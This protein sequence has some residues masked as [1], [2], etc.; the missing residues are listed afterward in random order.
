MREGQIEMEQFRQATETLAR[1]EDFLDQ[2]RAFM[3]HRAP[4]HL[5]YSLT[6]S[7]KQTTEGWTWKQDHRRRPQAEASA[8]DQQAARARQ[9]DA[10]WADVR[11]IRVPALLFRGEQSKILSPEVAQRT[12]EAMPDARLVAIPRATHNV[13]SDNPADFAAALDAYL[14]DVLPRRTSGA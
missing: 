3:P 12:V 11:A 6:H 10:L 5:R 4:E 8:E 14:T 7:L 1:F 2:A 13:H 9:A